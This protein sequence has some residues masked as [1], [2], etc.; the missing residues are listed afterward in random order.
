VRRIIAGLAVLWS[1]ACT[2]VGAVAPTATAFR[3]DPGNAP[4]TGPAATLQA[5]LSNF[6]FDAPASALEPLAADLVVRVN[7][8]RSGAGLTPL[9]AS[10]P[11]TAIA[12]LRARDMVARG[13]FDHVD[14]RRGTIEA[15]R[16][17]RP[18]GVVG[19]VAELLFKSTE[20]RN[21]LMAAAVDAWSADPANQSTL[22]DPSLSYAGAGVMT[23][24][25]WWVVVLLMTQNPPS[26]R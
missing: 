6:D 25:G 20:A 4:E 14:P 13:Y 24:D 19:R 16:L 7:Q 17:V 1:A 15:D 11:L 5:D 3:P 22:L 8:V 2:P 10:S 18:L 21:D 12:S 23:G 9:H 26:G